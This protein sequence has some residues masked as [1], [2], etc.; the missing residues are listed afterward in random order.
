M[1]IIGCDFHTRYQQIAGCPTRRYCERAR[2]NDQ[3][4]S[5]P[6]AVHA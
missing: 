6:T 1:L 2:S 4:R 5:R 3:H